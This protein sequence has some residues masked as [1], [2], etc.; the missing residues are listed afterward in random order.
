VE[1]PVPNDELPEW[2]KLA[3]G[4]SGNMKDLDPSLDD[5]R[6]FELSWKGAN[7]RWGRGW[8]LQDGQRADVDGCPA[9]PSGVRRDDQGGL[10]GEVGQ[11]P[12]GDQED[13]TTQGK[14]KGKELS[15]LRTGSFRL[16]PLPPRLH[17]L[18]SAGQPIAPN[19]SRAPLLSA[20]GR[21]DTKEVEDW[22]AESKRRK[23]I[24]RDM[25]R[26]DKGYEVMYR[27]IPRVSYD[28][29]SI[30]RM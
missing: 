20:R 25:I 4:S 11:W 9:G 19:L 6:E 13:S 7:G 3:P 2:L 24:W 16:P 30:V 21:V 10:R 26:G 18:R 8:A 17:A 23:K 28:L 14:G 12:A 1:R 29:A 22:Q 15:R 5:L 27:V